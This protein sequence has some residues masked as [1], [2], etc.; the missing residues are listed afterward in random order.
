MMDRMAERQVRTRL[1]AIEIELIGHLE[2]SFIAIC[3]GEPE[4]N[5]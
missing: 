4:V 1:L 5:D 2:M 3:R